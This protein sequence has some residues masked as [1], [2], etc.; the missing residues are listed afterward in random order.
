MPF[1][2][3]LIKLVKHSLKSAVGKYAGR[4]YRQ[5]KGIPTGGSLCV[6][7]A[8]ITVFYVMRKVVYNN[9]QLM[10]HVVHLKRYIDDGA[11]FSLVLKGNLSFG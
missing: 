10:K 1:R 11:G 2:S 9:S 5:K 4:W 7:L 3:W 8:N 6:E